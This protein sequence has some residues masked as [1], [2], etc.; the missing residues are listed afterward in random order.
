MSRAKLTVDLGALADNWRALDAMSACETAAV[1]KADG[2]GLRA[3][4][5]GPA[6]TEAGVKTFFVAQVEEGAVLREA[7]GPAP[8][9]SSLPG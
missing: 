9:F 2:Y 8:G 3:D 5:V 4:R 1:V 7:V 6:L